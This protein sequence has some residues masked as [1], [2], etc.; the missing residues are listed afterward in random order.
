MND[1]RKML[2]SVSI[3]VL[4]RDA[5]HF[6]LPIQSV[7][8]CSWLHSFILVE[9]PNSGMPEFRRNPPARVCVT[10]AMIRLVVTTQPQPA[11]A[12]QRKLQKS[13]KVKL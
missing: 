4:P 6:F 11:A 2:P 13:V 1:L 12:A 5:V 8:H 7:L 9:Y 3:M 10:H